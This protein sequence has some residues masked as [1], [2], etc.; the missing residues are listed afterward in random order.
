MEKVIRILMER[1]DLT[2]EEAIALIDETRE[3]ML[4]GDP[5]EAEEI[6]MDML[7]LEAD[8]ILDLI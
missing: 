4:A 7:G 5:W 6:M 1:D 3:E 2:R 8:Y